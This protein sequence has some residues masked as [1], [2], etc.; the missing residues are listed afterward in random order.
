MSYTLINQPYEFNPVN[1]PIW[2][3]PYSDQNVLQQFNYTID[4]YQYDRIYNTQ[5]FLG[6][7]LVPPRPTGEG[8]FDP[9]KILKSNINNDYNFPMSTIMSNI[10][11]GV[12]P[13]TDESCLAKFN[14]NYGYQQY[15]GMTFSS[16]ALYVS[17]TYSYVQL[18]GFDPSYTNYITTGDTVTLQMNTFSFNPSYNGTWKVGGQL[19]TGD[20]WIEMPF[21]VT[22]PFGGVITMY[23]KILGTST[24]NYAINGTRQYYNTNI[25][26]S[27][28]QSGLVNIYEPYTGTAPN[29]VM[30]QS[31]YA[32]TQFYFL[33]NY[34]APEQQL[35]K[36]I[37]PNQ[38]ETV[39]LL[40]YTQSSYQ[41]VVDSYD[42]NL[43]HIKQGTVNGT[44]LQDYILYNL[45][46]GTANISSSLLASTA[47]YYSV[48][49]ACG[50]GNDNFMLA[51]RHINTNCSRFPNIRI[52]FLNRLGG[53][54]YYNFNYDSKISVNINRTEF[55]KTLNWNY[56][57]GD[58]A[59][60]N[61]TID[62]EQQTIIN[63][64]WISQYDY[65]WLQELLTSPN[66]YV[67]DETTL[68]KL[69]II[70]TDTTYEQKSI[71]REKIFNMTLTFKYSYGQNLQSN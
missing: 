69:P 30:S 20:P 53:Y 17:G 12:I 49:L 33:T 35:W 71:L 18:L 42:S 22:D 7:Y 38:Y 45:P 9:H 24:Y 58:R 65:I 28:N 6:T 56:N 48:T 16:S 63:S 55:T 57:V 70:I 62:T 64:D 19:I 25:N 43:N 44:L 68:V 36:D 29:F 37:F 32:D 8:L 4:L 1:A 15:I 26:S 31:I 41:I 54:D 39:S 50:A 52:M 3:V 66:V 23:K 21:G 40:S 59:T 11:G 46:V 51:R 47:S 13:V 27:S 67:I 34:N 61:L 14:F 60:T 5:S 2:I 10:Y